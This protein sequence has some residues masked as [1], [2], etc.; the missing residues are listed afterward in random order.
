VVTLEKDYKYFD[1]F[2]SVLEQ[3]RCAVVICNLEHEI[4]YMN[5]TAIRYFDKRGGE[6][7][8]G[9]SIMDCHNGESQEKMRRV[10]EW[11]A[12]SPE[13]NIVYTS[14]NEKQNKDIYMVAL[15]AEGK[16]IGYYEKHEFRDRETMKMYD[17]W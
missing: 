12:A 16:L 11:F 2:K 9:Q 17:L 13:H 7:L 10:V 15:R 1:F 14:H 6:R 3:D 4:I 5:S 8:V